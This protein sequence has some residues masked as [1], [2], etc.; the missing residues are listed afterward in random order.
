[1]EEMGLMRTRI[2]W[3][4]WLMPMA[5]ALT[6]L[7]ARAQGVLDLDEG[8]PL[9]TALRA[10]AV[11]NQM[12]CAPDDGPLLPPLVRRYIARGQV[13]NNLYEVPP[14]ADAGMTSW[15]PLGHDRLEK[16]GFYGFGEAIFWRMSN[17]LQSQI[18]AFRGLWDADGGL[19]GTVGTF[20]GSKAPALNVDQAS[21]PGTYIPGFIVGV[22]WRFETGTAVEVNWWHLHQAKYS[23]TAGPEPFGFQARQ[24]LA[25]TFISSPVFNFPLQFAGA[26]KKFTFGTLNSAFGI[27]NA[28]SLQT[29]DFVQRADQYEI[30]GRFPVY[31][32]DCYRN[33][34]LFGPR[35]VWLWERFRWRTVS[36]DAFGLANGGTVGY[37]SNVDSERMYG[38]H[39][40]CGNEWF[41]GATPIG[42]FSISLDLELGLFANCVKENAKYELGDFSM[43]A[44]RSRKDYDM[45]PQ[46]QAKL[47]LWW[48]PTEGIQCRI[49]YDFSAFF[50]TIASPQPVDFN[51][52][53]VAPAWESGHTRIIEGLSAGI[54]FIF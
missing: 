48:Y 46:T 15:T 2:H 23:A 49:G 30:S 27:W 22:G 29:I 1:M 11:S 20:I 12:G 52:G 38:L 43:S 3:L 17:P 36:A 16:G 35:V 51:F 39:V 44:S 19:S 26:A 18:I 42:A 24:D 34:A 41:L 10:I 31:E 33:Y 8:P 5:I 21:G 6:P 13:G 47:N 7:T 4:V 37:Y 9:A 25:D 50:N 45:V 53:A 32:G 40:G 14:N 28:S 54:G